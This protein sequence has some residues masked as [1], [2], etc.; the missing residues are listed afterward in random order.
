MKIFRNFFTFILA[1]Y[2]VSV[3]LGG[4]NVTTW[5]TEMGYC[6]RPGVIPEDDPKTC[7][8]NFDPPRRGWIP[9]LEPLEV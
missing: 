7:H 2:L 9:T 4:F 5:A 8:H 1:F 3:G 6:R